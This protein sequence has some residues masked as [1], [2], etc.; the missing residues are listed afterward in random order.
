MTRRQVAAGSG[1]APTVSSVY[2]L[3]FG[4]FVLCCV[5]TL[6]PAGTDGAVLPA[7]I[8][9]SP[10]YFGGIVPANGRFGKKIQHFPTVLSTA[11]QH[12]G[13]IGGRELHQAEGNRADNA[14]YHQDQQ[15]HVQ[16]AVGR[17][18][19]AGRGSHRLH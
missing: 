1:T 4:L 14:E 18:D 5:G 11:A 10:V 8:A 2:V 7:A 12:P 13:T 6:I 19:E 15:L 9:D 17:V 16:A 3:L